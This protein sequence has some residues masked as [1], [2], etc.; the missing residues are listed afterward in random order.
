M[1]W[2]LVIVNFIAFII[3][4]IDKYKAIRSK[5]RISEKELFALSILGGSLG[6]MIGMRLFHHKTKKISFWLINILS[7]II[8]SYLLINS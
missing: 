5:Y 4:G 3:Y 2:Y 8:W 1:I 6:S 7:L